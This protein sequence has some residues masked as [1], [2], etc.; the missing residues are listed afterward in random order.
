MPFDTATL[1]IHWHGGQLSIKGDVSS[2]AH[3]A[4][5]RQ[6]AGSLFADARLIVEL[7]YP[8]AMP[9]GWAL[10]TEL[11][12][13]A[14]AQ[15]FAASATVRVGG[16]SVRGLTR[17]KPGWQGA[18]LRLQEHMLRGMTFDADMQEISVTTSLQD[19]CRALFDATLR[20]QSVEFSRSSEQI[21]SNAFAL[22]DELILISAD[23]PGASISITGHTDNTGN[24]ATNR[25]LSG[26]RA[27][28]VL[29]YMEAGGIAADRMTAKGLGATRPLLDEDSNRA[30]R[31]N[32]RIEFEFSYR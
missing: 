25:A 28:A 13:R 15:T 29:T 6:T 4:I 31:L 12:L 9:P 24:E 20:S 30:R 32:R 10:T 8:S 1:R 17:D 2:A 3:E 16:I 11:A 18:A 5:L 14:V 23:C 19:Q 26:A 22:L 7:D 27:R 21:N